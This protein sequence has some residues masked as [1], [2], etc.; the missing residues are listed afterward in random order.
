LTLNN[1]QADRWYL[2]DARFVRRLRDAPAL[3]WIGHASTY[4]GGVLIVTALSVGTAFFVPWFLGPAAFGTY[5]LL[6]SLFI[7]ANKSDLGLSQLADRKLAVEQRA[8]P[9]C[10]SAIL[11][12]RVIIGAIMLGMIVPLAMGI[13]YIT[14]TLPAADT[15]LAIAAGGAFMMANGPVTVFRATSKIWEFTASALLLQAG[16]TAPR[17]AGLAVGGVTGCFAA[18]ALWYGLLAAL[19][20]KSAASPAARPTPLL[21]L[22]RLALPLFAFNACWEIYLSANRWISASVSSAGDFGQFAFGANLAFTGI[23]MLATIA[24]VRYPRILAQIGKNGS[25]ACSDLIEREAFL[26]CLVL[27]LG[28]ALAIFVVGPMIELVFPRFETAV[29]VTRAL[30]ISC[31]P[32]SVVAS[33]LPIVI[34]VSLR[35]WAH[36]ARIFLPALLILLG[37]MITADRLGGITGQAWGCTAA[38]FALIVSLVAFSCSLGIVKRSAAFRI[39]LFQAAAVAC[40]TSLALALRPAATIPPNETVPPAGWDVTFADNFKSLQFWDGPGLG[41][42]ESFYAWGSRTNDTNNEREYYVDRRPGHDQAA[43][44]SLLPIDGSGLVIQARPVPISDQPF[45]ERLPYASGLLTTFHSFSFTYGY[46]EMR[47]RIPK[48]KWLW[49]AFWLLPVDKTW[50]PETD[51]MEVLGQNTMEFHATVY[52]RDNGNHTEV[53]STIQD[54][55]EDFD[56]YA[57]TWTADDII[58]YFDGRPVA[59]AP[60][61]AD[62]HNPM[63][64]LVNLALGGGR[65]RDSSTVFPAEFRINWIPVFQGPAAW[66]CSAGEGTL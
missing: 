28:A 39:I 10:A 49:P 23:G 58:W 64:L 60:T 24:Q 11:R 59:L 25:C 56:I 17:L 2:L 51:V 55:S 44:Q 54:L 36:A 45:A 50:P 35:P 38:G 21:P 37:A 3:R 12:A 61:P 1:P 43:I 4:S 34:S 41:I 48:G 30:A 40:L 18:L 22:L 52:S 7:Y 29:P 31:V 6:T 20:S 26:L 27:S 66:R 8:H 63:Y 53:S 57:V 5:T 33:I 47:A 46:E 19:L 16:L 15:G 42:W 9:D 13:T 62:M 14:D 65:N 32:L